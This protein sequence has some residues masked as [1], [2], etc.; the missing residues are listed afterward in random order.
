MDHPNIAKVFEAGST[1]KGRPY[2]AMELV[3]GVPITEYCDENNLDIKQRLKL[4]MDVC[5]AVEHAHQKGVMH[6]DI[7]PSNV[8]VALHD[9]RPVPKV[10]DFGIA[11]ATERKLTEKTLFTEFRQFIGTPEYMSPEQAEFSNIEIDIRTDVYS[12]GVLL[13]ELLTGNTPFDAKE[14]RSTSFNEICRIIRESEPPKPSTRLSRLGDELDEIAR[15]RQIKPGEVCRIVRGDLDW[16]VIRALEKDRTRRYQT[17][18]DLAVDIKRHLDDEPVLAGPPSASYRLHKFIRRN[19]VAV[20]TFSLVAAALAFGAT[21]ATIAVWNSS[22]LAGKL[23]HA[24]GM[25]QRHVWDVPPDSTLLGG[26]SR[27][28]R[29]MSYVD[30]TLGNLAVYDLTLKKSWQVTKNTDPTWETSSGSN[31]SSVISHDGKQIAYS[32]RIHQTPEFYDLRLID[33]DGTSMKVLYHDPNVVF[34]II[35]RDFSPDGSEILAYYCEAKANLVDQNT[36]KRFRRGH[37]VLVSTVDG[38]VRTLKTWNRRGVP[39]RACFSPDGRY[40][41]YDFEQEDDLNRQ[42]IFLMN[43]DDGVEVSLIEH[44]AN[45]QLYGWTP[46]GRRVI[47]TSDRS[48]NRD[49][50]MIELVDGIPQRRPRELIG[51]FAGWPIGLTDDGSMYYSRDTTACNVYLAWLDATGLNFEDEPELVSSQFV[52]S[53]VMADFSPD[54]SLLAYRIGNSIASGKSLAI[55]SVRTSKEQLISPEELFK[56]SSRM[57]GPRWSP[58]GQSLLVWGQNSEG[59]YGLY[60]VKVETGLSELVLGLGDGRARRAVWSPDGNAIYIRSPFKLTLLDLAT[61]QETELYPEAGGVRGMDISPDGR[62]LA[63]YQGGSSLVVM[64]SEGGELREVVHLNEDEVNVTQRSFLRWTPDGDHLLFSKG[65]SRIWKVH[66]ASGLQ[67]PIGP[68]IEG[69]LNAAMHPDGR[70]V[71]F[72]VQQKGSALWVME[73]FLPD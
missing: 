68:A 30:W 71:A 44:P 13:Y 70:Q 18:S 22:G 29:Y 10:I 63:F 9:G 15:K 34:C 69:L 50:W 37:L 31:E 33:T 11:K 24:A 23:H 55:C 3:K 51:P 62:W 16:I 38:S 12:L 2:F 1:E 66:V 6:R 39:K 67:Q 28:G 7:K 72:T 35:P 59:L 48:S 41:A 58:N 5:K 45:D 27:D 26:I 61:G 21:A 40:I 36:G 52:G 49:L 47:F 73:N 57:L 19:R 42:D 56:T 14:L 60:S 43:L 17:A 64:P 8:M 53:T 54:G 4:F 46:D 32:W 25:V 65:E 20:I